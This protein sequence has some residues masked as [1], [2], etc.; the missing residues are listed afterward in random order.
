MKNKLILG[1][2]CTILIFL[3]AIISTV[4]YAHSFD[5][6]C[7]P[8]EIEKNPSCTDDN[9]KALRATI[10]LWISWFVCVTFYII[11]NNRVS[12]V[13]TFLTV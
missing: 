11:L 8:E 12:V 7:T 5:K 1:L 3:G 2:T 4:I 9:S 13:D 6:K 10:G